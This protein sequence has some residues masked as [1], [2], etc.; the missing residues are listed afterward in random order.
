[1]KRRSMFTHV[2]HLFAV[3]FIVIFL[4]ASDSSS[5]GSAMGTNWEVE[6]ESESNTG[7]MP[8]LLLSENERQ[9][10]YTV[11]INMETTELMNGLRLLSETVV[12]FNGWVERDLS[13]GDIERNAK[14]IL[15]IPTENLVEFLAFIEFNY[16]VISS[17]KEINDFTAAYE[18][19]V[20]HVEDL[21][22]QEQQ[23]LANLNED[24]K[25]NEIRAQ[26]SDLEASIAGLQ[27]AIAYPHVTI[28]LAEVT[29]PG[30]E[31]EV[32][33]EE[34]EVLEEE[35]EEVIAVPERPETFGDQLQN[36]FTNSLNNL[37]AVFQ[38]I[39]S[40]LPWVL[41]IAILVVPPIFIV[42]KHKKH[43]KE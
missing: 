13:S 30:E 37:L 36:T 40:I 41:L 20:V 43:K 34:I 25:V 18:R 1:M 5:V 10:V 11:E 28:R 24:E 32:P 38:A 9:L 15:R 42:K 39:L 31:I 7:E 3:I 17:E 4:A 6:E 12:E 2:I 26:I 16:N 29:I 21:R 8:V 14:L 33:E 22:E 27:H 35:I 23:L 19:D